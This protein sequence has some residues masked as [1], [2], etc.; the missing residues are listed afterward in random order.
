[1]VVIINKNIIKNITTRGRKFKI[2]VAILIVAS[3]VVSA[4][5]VSSS[6]Q[7]TMKMNIFPEQYVSICVVDNESVTGWRNTNATSLDSL[8]GSIVNEFIGAVPTYPWYCSDEPITFSNVSGGD[9]KTIWIKSCTIPQGTSLGGWLVFKVTCDTGLTINEADSVED[10]LMEFQ[11]MHRGLDNNIFYTDSNNH[12]GAMV[13]ISND[14]H[15]F[16]FAIGYIDASESYENITR[17]DM[18]FHDFACGEYTVDV[19]FTKT[20]PSC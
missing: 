12:C 11:Y 2:A 19:Y 15:S 17:V 5:L 4:I 1:M 14:S 13:Y 18:T 6:Q 16:L 9:T 8:C 7:V 3:V 10:F 20:R